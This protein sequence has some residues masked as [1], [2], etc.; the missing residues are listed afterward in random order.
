MH[1]SRRNEKCLQYNLPNLRFNSKHTHSCFHPHGSFL[2]KNKKR[3]IKSGTSEKN[4]DY[5]CCIK[6][7]GYFLQICMNF[8]LLPQKD[9]TTILC[10]PTHF[11]EIMKLKINVID[12][13]FWNYTDK[14]IENI[15]EFISLMQNIVNIR[16]LFYWMLFIVEI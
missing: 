1:L 10:I 16:L 4:L 11:Y 3:V 14:I 6:K 5:V 12:I 13:L 7:G 8:D 15:F 2:Y 9:L